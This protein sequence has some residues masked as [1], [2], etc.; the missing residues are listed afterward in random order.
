MAIVVCHVTAC[1]VTALVLPF[2]NEEMPPRGRETVPWKVNEVK[3]KM[4][5][6][7]VCAANVAYDNRYSFVG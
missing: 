2:F 3:W 1:D 4:F 6:Q 7:N 5:P